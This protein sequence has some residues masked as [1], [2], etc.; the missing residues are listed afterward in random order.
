MTATRT[1]SANFATKTATS[2]KR[3][4]GWMNFS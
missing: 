2:G 4:A 1:P 3:E